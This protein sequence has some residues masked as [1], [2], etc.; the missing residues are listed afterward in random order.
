[1]PDGLHST[2]DGVWGAVWSGR[3]SPLGLV[4]R[5]EPNLAA[6]N[7]DA[8]ASPQGSF[9]VVMDA[10]APAWWEAW[11]GGLTLAVVRANRLGYYGL[12]NDTQYSR[13]SVTIAGTYFYKVSRTSLVARA[14][15]ER[16]GAGPLRLR[17]GAP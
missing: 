1:M 8:G 11:R 3:Y 14:T 4:E 6:V 15:V 12:G 17:A 10:Q 7:L 9:A 5:P 13:D 16:P 2:V